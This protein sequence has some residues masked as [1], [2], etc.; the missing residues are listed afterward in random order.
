[1][2]RNLNKDRLDGEL[3]ATA[4]I[5]PTD[6]TTINAGL[7]TGTN[8]LNQ[9][10]TF[11]PRLSASWEATSQLTLNASGGIYRQ[12]LPL[13][14]RSQQPE[15]DSLRDPYSR[16]LV[17]GFDYL[18]GN[19]T[20]FSVEFYDKQYRQLPIQPEGYDQGFPTY[21]FDTQTFYDELDDHG[22]GYA[23][24][25]DL[26]LHRKM[27]SGLYGT[28]SGSFFRSRYKDFSGEWQNRDFDV[29]YLLSAIGGYRPSQKWELSARW[30]Y[31]G[32][33][34][35]T[36][37]DVTRSS[38][39]GQTILDGARY[40]S[41]RLPAFHSFYVR[42]DRRIFLN[43]LT[44][45]TFVEMWNAYNRSNVET[46]Y[47]NRNTGQPDELNQFSILPVGGFTIEF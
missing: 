11:S 9:N 33:R 25:V 12:N 26:M 10:L 14:I 23:R 43:S 28:I 19:A 4:I 17:A 35:F 42:M 30:T 41:E 20:K 1:M 46:I 34:P 47:W 8:N 6:Q 37:I 7:R 5:K 31:I 38:Q 40:N 44:I 27:K 45:V 2:T 3:F 22:E 39:A 13:F 15:F 16:H 36:P 29:D 18:L 24:G 21:V 32:S